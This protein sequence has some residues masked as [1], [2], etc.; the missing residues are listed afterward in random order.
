[1]FKTPMKES[2]ENRVEIVDFTYDVVEKAMKYCYH[3]NLEPD[4]SFDEVF[5][6]LK[7]AD[8]YDI[9]ALKVIIFL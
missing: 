2:I 8:K 7:F 1:M 6:L 5:L 4:A 9:T 3:Y